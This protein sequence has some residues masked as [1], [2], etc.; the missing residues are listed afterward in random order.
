MWLSAAS[1]S[2]GAPAAGSSS[3][4]DEDV[5][6]PGVGAGVCKRG[7]LRKQKSGARRYFVLRLA[8]ADGPARLECYDSAR[9][10]RRGARGSGSGPR[11][12]RVVA[13][14]QCFSVSRRAS[15]R[16][17]HLIALFTPDRC[18]ALAA[19]DEAEQR[20]WYRLLSRVI[21]DGRRDDDHDDDPD[22][23]RARPAA[24][25]PGL[26][27]DVWQVV[28]KRRGLGRRR[29][30]SGVFRLCLTDREA[31]FV[32]LHTE[33]ASV[34]LQLLSIRRCGH[35]ERFF[36]LEVG[37][38]T[39]IG[40][41][42]LWM[43]V[44]DGV[45]ARHMHEL[46][47]E[48][49][50][51]LC[52]HE[53]RA[54]CRAA[55]PGLGAHLPSLLAT[56]RPPEPRSDEPGG[57]WRRIRFQRLGPREAPGRAEDAPSAPDPAPARRARRAASAPAGCFRRFSRNPAP[58][59]PPAASP[60]D[61]ARPASGTS[62]TAP[63]R[64]REGR[65]SPRREEHE[66][67]EGDYV[68][69]NA[70]GAEGGRSPG[71][72]RFSPVAHEVGP[73]DGGP[74][75]TPRS[76]GGRKDGWGRVFRS[77]KGSGSGGGGG[78]EPSQ[79]RKKRSYFS[80]FT[81]S[82]PRPPPPPPPVPPAPAGRA[83]GGKGKSG[84]RFRLSF[85]AKGRKEAKVES[86]PETTA[87]DPARVGVV[88]PEEDDPYVPMR[89]AAAA[90]LDSTGDY[91]TMAPQQP[92][93]SKPRSSRRL[94]GDS[95][96]YLMMFRR[97]SPPAA[98][99]PPRAP[100]PEKEDE[101][102]DDDSDG[103][104]MFMAPGP[105]AIPEPFPSPQGGAS[106]NRWNFCAP[107]P[108]PA[109]ISPG[110]RLDRREY[111]PTL[112]GQFL[113]EGAC[114]G[115]SPRDRVSDPFAEGAFAGSGHDIVETPAQPKGKRPSRLPFMTKG[116]KVQ[117]RSP[118]PTQDR[119]E[120]D[121]ASVSVDLDDP[122][123]AR[124][125]PAP[126]APCP[127][128]TRGLLAEPD[129][130]AFSHS[131][132]VQFRVPFLSLANLSHLLRV[133]LG[134][135]LFSLDPASWPLLPGAAGGTVNVEVLFNS[136][137]TPP[138]PFADSAL[139]YDPETGRIYVVDPF[140]ECCMGISLS[141]N[142]C[143]E[144]EPERGGPSRRSPAGPNDSLDGHPSGAAAAPWALVVGPALAAASVLAAAPDLGAAAASMEV[145]AAW[146]SASVRRLP[147]VANAA[148]PARGAPEISPGPPR[149][150]PNPFA[151]P[152]RGDN[153]PPRAAAAAAA[154]SVPPPRRRVPRPPERDDSDDDD[155]Y[156]RMDFGRAD[157][158]DFD[159]P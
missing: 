24:A 68:L 11:P 54:R 132:N 59:E 42:E 65:P 82:K 10:F 122:E 28:V 154:P 141:P 36:V 112:R 95:K 98:P 137:M 156:V 67:D 83:S 127:P 62:G 109:R 145:A 61:R 17:P 57:W 111:V 23:A 159:A 76:G 115:G 34:V 27:R 124:H 133:I 47:L 73:S 149:R 45:V 14:H 80:R 85:S 90:P 135:D 142:L 22:A 30:L 131:V 155:T 49:M 43:Q 21:L 53:Y 40:P 31:L 118:E 114:E 63:G 108:N 7:Y 2:R 52:A 126:L 117:P 148:G 88:D 32:R 147:L 3:D 18:L 97:P 56:R 51:A 72:D 20:S 8:S 99:R 50:R 153:E 94:S 64:P 152:A 151:A 146:D 116:N 157:N 77:G 5:G 101:S 128:P 123:S 81:A 140:S 41:G 93:A 29:D 134:G 37:R 107:P 91:M 71:T 9:K 106:L 86:A 130:L 6:A 44:D 84:G 102:Q 92:S 48:K 138:V 13:L 158:K 144:E 100:E 125:S 87:Q 16:H 39:G 79:P 96:G 25:P 35:S 129:Q 74:R 33:R 60:G 12:R 143:S 70:R 66:D 89:P 15:A 150:A 113:G 121:R 105:G 78:G 75:D 110:G 136:A 139:R 55:P 104:Y 26:F 120:R 46:F 103:D 58:R 1:R 38:T 119:R 19:P 69:M 4:E